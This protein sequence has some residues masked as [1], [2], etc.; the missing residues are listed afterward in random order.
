[1]ILGRWSV[2]VFAFN[3]FIFLIWHR[4]AF[5]FL[6]SLYFIL[7]LIHQLSFIRSMLLC[8]NLVIICSLSLIS[9]NYLLHGLWINRALSYL[10]NSYM[11]KGVEERLYCTRSHFWHRQPVLAL[12][13]GINPSI[14]RKAYSSQSQQLSLW[15]LPLDMPLRLVVFYSSLP[16]LISCLSF[17]N[18]FHLQGPSS[19]ESQGT[20]Y[21]VTLSAGIDF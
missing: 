7:P 18:L 12:L 5:V 8:V 17:L 11:L 4:V 10:Q 1:M 16:S 6:L 9:F 21:F 14:R 3:W 20:W 19:V 15:K 13:S 2:L